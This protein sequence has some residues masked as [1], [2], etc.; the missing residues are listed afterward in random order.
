MAQI[1]FYRGADVSLPA[2]QNGAVYIVS[3][4]NFEPTDTTGN[5]FYLGD[6]YVDVDEGKRVHIKPEDAIYYKTDDD[7]AN[8][9]EWQSASIADKVYILIDNTGP[10][11]AVGDGITNVQYLN[12]K[13]IDATYTPASATPAAVS[14]AAS[15]GTSVNY[16]REDHVHNIAVASGATNG[17]ISIAGQ[18]VSVKG[19]GSAAYTNTSAYPSAAFKTVKVGSTNIVADS[20]DD[21]FELVAGNDI[22]LTPDATNDKVTVSATVPSA[23][24]TT[25]KMDGTAAVGTETKWAHGDHVHPTDTS[26]APKSHATTATTYGVGTDSN[27]GHLK[28]A[29]SATTAS[30]TSSGVAATPKAVACAVAA[31]SAAIPAASTVAGSAIGSAATGSSTA[32][33]RA[34]HVHS[35]NYSTITAALGLTPVDSSGVTTIITNQKGVANGLAQLDANGTVP[36]SQ[37]PSYVDDVLE[38]IGKSA[39][40]ATGETGKIYVDKSTNL[41]YRW[42]GSAY[43]EISPSLALGETSST[44]Y[45][46]DKG[47]ANADTIATLKALAFKN[48][49]SASYQP[50]GTLTITLPTASKNVVSSVSTGTVVTAVTTA[51][52]TMVTGVTTASQTVATGGTTATISVSGE[53]L[54]I[55]ASVVTSMS[56][57]SI[58]KVTSVSTASKNVVSSVSTGTGVTAVS[59]AAQTIVT[60]QATT[61]TFTGTTA[62]ITVA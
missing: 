22:V 57:A 52:Q 24:S 14:S 7:W 62:T 6:M 40:P 12:F 60:G 17:T 15:V 41:T 42:G 33:A 51:A 9:P 19:L 23:S 31:V 45:P 1:R 35:I 53:L 26:R 18:E 49:A 5:G 28:L 16:A 54:T 48:N 11:I 46:G 43:V 8:S 32:Y 4:Q 2:Y 30:N 13:P 58:Y 59:T 37:L 20:V 10:K 55:P 56:T 50:S 3:N 29:D 47:K 25:P 39:F 34:D 27:Y 36:S 21:T 38:Y 44:A 61:A